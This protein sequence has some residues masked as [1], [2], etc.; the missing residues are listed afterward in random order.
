MH[1]PA[2]KYVLILSFRPL[3]QESSHVN[4]RREF[5]LIPSHS[6]PRPSPQTHQPHAPIT[7]PSPPSRCSQVR[8]RMY[9]HHYYRK[10]TAFDE[11][12]ILKNLSV[13]LRRELG[14]HLLHSSIFRIP[15]FQIL[16]SPSMLDTYII[17]YV[18]FEHK[19]CLCKSHVYY[20][21]QVTTTTKS[22]SG[23]R[24]GHGTSGCAAE[25]PPTIPVHAWQHALHLIG[26]R[27]HGHVRPH[28]GEWVSG[29]GS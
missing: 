10:K 14:L 27:G 7:I 26:D 24:H 21:R 5:A 28:Q 29:C 22:T 25:H 20:I 8:I 16:V 12:E 13:F 23:P 3:K 15:L 11:R 19:K 4:Q 9:F 6:I 2:W 1:I 18:L 17:V